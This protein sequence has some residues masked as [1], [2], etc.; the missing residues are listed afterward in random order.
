MIDL[1]STAEIPKPKSKIS[2]LHILG[3][4]F[5]LLGIGLFIYFINE[6]GFSTILDG[7]GKIGFDGF[8][9]IL[10]IY[11]L[12]LSCRAWAWKL[13]V[14]DPYKITFSEAIQAVIIGESLSTM[15]PLGILVSGTAKAVAVKRRIPLVVG[16]SSVATENLFFSLGA[17]LVIILGGVLFLRSFEL[18]EGWVFTIDLTIGII[19]ILTILGFLMVIRQWHF[20]SSICESLY[21]RGV[22]KRFLATGRKKV[23]VFEDLVY[24][25]YRQHPEYFVPIFLLQVAFHAFGV[26]EIWFVLSRISEVLPTVSTAFL[27]ES[28]SRIILVVFKL[29]PFMIGV[30]EAGA[31]FVAETLALGAGVGI[32]LPIIRKV[33]VLF[34]TGIGLII[35]LKRE[36][37]ITELFNHQEAVLKEETENQ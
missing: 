31:Q 24:S 18:P 12:R 1:N 36:L 30:D 33:R 28:V 26:L 25:F 14:S 22:L 8:A 13:S 35:I 17:G 4:L 29:I 11:L 2:R 7:I 5:T 10:F 9:L 34:W 27:L 3:V 21:K 37:S 15:I 32:T 23:R 20:L 19:T 16:L 6:V